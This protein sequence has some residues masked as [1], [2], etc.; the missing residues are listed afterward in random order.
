MTSQKKL[1]F[2]TSNNNAKDDNSINNNTNNFKLN[3]KVKDNPMLYIDIE[4]E[5]NNYIEDSI[6]LLETN[7]LLNNRDERDK[8]ELVDKIVLNDLKTNNSRLIDKESELFDTYNNLAKEYNKIIKELNVLDNKEVLNKI[9][10]LGNDNNIKT[11]VNSLTNSLDLNNFNNSTGIISNKLKFNDKEL[12][13]DVENK[14]SSNLFN[15]NNTNNNNNKETK[16]KKPETS[17]VKFVNNNKYIN[18]KKNNIQINDLDYSKL[19]FNIKNELKNDIENKYSRVLVL[20]YN[21]K[22]YKLKLNNLIKAL[23][24]LD[25]SYDCANLLPKELKSLIENFKNK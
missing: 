1:K 14:A 25:K 7:S 4:E 17:Y 3:T 22:S 20:K 19:N 10:K 2:I 16:L 8:Y 6:Q 12:N 23:N 15:N 11:I 5:V 18:S 21:I 24:L 13:V 9:K